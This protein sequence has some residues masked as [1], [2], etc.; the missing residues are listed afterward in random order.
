MTPKSGQRARIAHDEMKLME[1]SATKT[2][3][4]VVI[5]V[6]NKGPHIHRSVSS[7][8]N[9]RFEDFELII[10]NDASTD[11]SLEEIMK[12]DDPRIRVFHRDQP[13]PGGYAARN[14]GIREARAEW[15]VF[16]DADDEWF[17]EH[18][19][20]FHALVGNHQEFL[21]FGCGCRNVVNLKPNGKHSYLDAYYRKNRQRGDHTITFLD[22]L[23]DENRGLRPLN[24]STAMI[25]RD[26]LREVNGFPEGKVVR[27]GDVDTWLRCIEYAGG[28]AWSAHVG[29]TY[30]RDSVN[31]VTRNTWSDANY[32]LE[33]IKSLQ[34]K[35][36]GSVLLE[37]RRFANRRVTSAWK[38]NDNGQTKKN[39]CLHRSIDFKIESLGFR[40]RSIVREIRSA[41]RQLFSRNG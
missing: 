17:P 9:Q 29:A 5:P 1:E 7:V 16:L 12:F 35:Y 11:N 10:V 37:L 2:F 4:S 14:V 31:M 38:L 20:R 41:V 33:T 6:Y 22:Y 13:G 40:I 27:G 26:V 25:A 8:L 19:E 15:V 23:K 18:L 21:V 34:K 30:H 28:L 3:F 39:F 36:S 32:Q 24:G